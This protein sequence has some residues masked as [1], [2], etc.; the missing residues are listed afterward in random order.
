MLCS[1]S[2]IVG[3][4]S[5]CCHQNR[6]CITDAEWN[7]MITSIKITLGRGMERQSNRLRGDAICW[8]QQSTNVAD[9]ITTNNKKNISKISIV[10]KM[11]NSKNQS[12]RVQSMA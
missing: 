8:R 10:G 1:N 3:T 5:R 4:N 12:H 6:K 9:I 7:R 2:C 11:K